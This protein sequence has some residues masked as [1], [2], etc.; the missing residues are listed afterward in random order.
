MNSLADPA[1][2]KPILPLKY[3]EDRMRAR[4]PADAKE[5]RSKHFFSKLSLVSHT[6]SSAV[7][8]LLLCFPILFTR[9]HTT[10]HFSS[11]P[12]PHFSPKNPFP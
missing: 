11:T 8:Q 7:A 4:N 9:F 3:F 2:T 6:S 10:E 12:N 1:K 5:V